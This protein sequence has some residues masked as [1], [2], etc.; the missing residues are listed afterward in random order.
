MAMNSVQTLGAPASTEIPEDA[1]IG[2]ASEE[3]IERLESDVSQMAE[4][5]LRYR[6]N[7][8][9]QLKQALDLLKSAERFDVTSSR[10]G[11][12]GDSDQGAG[13]MSAAVARDAE[14]SK[15]VQL[16]REKTAAN[17]SMAPILLKRMKDCVSLID[18]LST[19]EDST[20]RIH[21]TFNR[22]GSIS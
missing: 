15:K 22:K 2:N 11:T 16:L 3:E 20:I 1:E 13:E 9:D 19:Q 18:N 4:K 21:S 10:P 7:L 14:M 8:P 5:I 17:A 6:T 12:S